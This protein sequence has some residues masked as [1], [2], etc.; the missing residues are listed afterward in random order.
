MH[1]NLPTLIR[2]LFSLLSP[3]FVPI[4][5][6]EYHPCLRGRGFS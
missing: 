6:I 4:G 5:S 2:I 1:I 3:S